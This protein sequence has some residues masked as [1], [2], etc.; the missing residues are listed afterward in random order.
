MKKIL[1]TGATGFIGGAVVAEILTNRNDEIYVLVRARDASQG[2]QRIRENLR[3][4][5]CAEKYINRIQLQHIIIGDLLTPDDFLNDKRINVITHVINCAAIASFGDNSDIWKVNVDG[6][7][8]FAEKMA[9][10][11]GFEKFVHVGTAMSAVP[12]AGSIVREDMV[13]TKEENHI[14]QYTYSKSFVERRMK[15]KLPHLPLIIARPSI[16]VGHSSVGCTPSSSI[17]WVFKMALMLEK[18]LCS[19]N[20]K[21]DVIPVDYC[22]R[23]LLFLLDQGKS[24]DAVYHIS[25]GQLCSNTF[26]QI[27]QAIALAEHENPLAEN[28]RQVE[29]SEIIKERKNFKH[30]YGPCNERLMLRAMKLYGEFAKLNVVFS[31]DKLLQLGMTSPPEFISYI[32]KCIATTKGHAIQELMRVDFK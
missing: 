32:D 23:S 3:R 10:L 4:F 5:G 28:Y 25:A 7:F 8:R 29:F 24:E 21:V 26:S 22:A 12:K 17:F 31:N 16:V 13:L 27:D 20:D 14:V 19:L 30:I 15:E 9:S 1:V 11:S 6:T 2:L 18:F